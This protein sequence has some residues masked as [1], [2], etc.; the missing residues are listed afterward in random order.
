[1]AFFTFLEVTH[2]STNKFQGLSDRALVEAMAR[3]KV[4]L[5]WAT[6][7]KAKNKARISEIRHELQ[8]RKAMR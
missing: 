5:L 6:T 8:V 3:L 1:M 4:S 2:M 7:Q